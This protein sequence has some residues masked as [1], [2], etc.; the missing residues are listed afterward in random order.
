MHE[1]VSAIGSDLECDLL[2]EVKRSPYFSLIVDESTDI[3]VHKQL[4]LSIQYLSLE[5][6]SVKTRYLKK[7]LDMSGPGKSPSVTS[8]VIVDLLEHHVMVQLLCLESAKEQCFS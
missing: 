8:E 5:T 4:A 6:A 3:S 2:S 1:I 7:L